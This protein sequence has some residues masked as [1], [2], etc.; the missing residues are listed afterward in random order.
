MDSNRILMETLHYAHY[1]QGTKQ[2]LGWYSTDIH[3]TIV[4]GEYDLSTIPTP[5]M[6]ATLEEWRLAVDNGHNKV[7]LTD[8]TTLKF[9]FRSQEQRLEDFK[10]FERLTRKESVRVST[11]NSSGNIFQADEGSLNSMATAIVAL[12]EGETILWRLEDNS[13]VAVTREVLREALRLGVQN[14]SFLMEEV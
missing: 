6:E 10:R 7:D 8:G 14:R 13:E 1:K 3:A 11:I 4:D 2:I 9:D 5:R 12:D